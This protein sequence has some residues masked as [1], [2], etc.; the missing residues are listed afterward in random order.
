MN[1]FFLSETNTSKTQY[2]Q[3]SCVSFKVVTLEGHS[4]FLTMLPLL[5]IPLK[6]FWHRLQ[7][8][9]HTFYNYLKG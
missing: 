6:L 3:M 5:K 7:S 4:S 2:I 8:Q 1:F 9:L